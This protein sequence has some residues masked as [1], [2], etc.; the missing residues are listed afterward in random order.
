MLSVE[1][2]DLSKSYGKTRVL[3]RVDL[4]LQEP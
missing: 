3:E 2:K 1:I 4:K